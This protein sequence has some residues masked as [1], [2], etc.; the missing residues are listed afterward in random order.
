HPTTS[1]PSIRAS[2]GL[3][4]EAFPPQKRLDVLSPGE[5]GPSPDRP[6]RDPGRRG[7]VK[8]RPPQ[9]PTFRQG[10]DKYGIETIA[11]PGRI[12]YVHLKR[13][14]LKGVGRRVHRDAQRPAGDDDQLRPHLQERPRAGAD[15][16]ATKEPADAQ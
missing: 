12:G 15:V 16:V 6:D 3:V 1:F 5:P 14:L 13:A 11:R 9:L 2:S 8:R 10:G 4:E 7:R